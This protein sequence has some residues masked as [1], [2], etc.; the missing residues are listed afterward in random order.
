MARI[1]IAD[2]DLHFSGSLERNL[3]EHLWD[4]EIARDGREALR[5][6]SDKY[7]DVLI[8][9]LAAP[10]AGGLEILRIMQQ[11]GIRT[12]VVV[13]AECPTVEKAVQ[14]IKAGAQE[15]VQKSIEAADFSHI[16]CTV[17][18]RRRCSPHYLANR[19]DLFIRD[20]CSLASLKPGDLCE[21]F[22]ISASYVSQLFR[23]HIGTPFRKRLTYYRIQRAKRL[24]ESTDQLL[25]LIAEQCGF[26]NQGRLT[27]AFHSIEGISPRRYREICKD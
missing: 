9:D 17:L 2:S 7:F 27:E 4:V 18:E 25:Y 20:H 11:R 10:G 26:K 22:S 21:H 15:F 12:D 1:L 24:I 19:L 3:R 5:Y 14:A 23:K 16:I 8:L 13:T 6:L